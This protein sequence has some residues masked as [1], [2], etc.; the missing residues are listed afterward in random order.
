MGVD[1]EHRSG[2]ESRLLVASVEDPQAP[3][4]GA[5]VDSGE[6][7]E[8]LSRARDALQELHIHLYTVAQTRLLVR[9]QRLLWALC[10]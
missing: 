9:F 2:T 4:A 1:R 6:L 10:F 3:N 8:A 7:I 5:I